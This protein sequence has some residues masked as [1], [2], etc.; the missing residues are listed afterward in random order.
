[1]SEDSKQ[2]T[3][4]N[5]DSFTNLL[6][7]RGAPPSASA[8]IY[9]HESRKSNELLSLGGPKGASVSVLPPPQSIS[10]ERIDFFSRSA[11]PPAASFA[12]GFKHSQIGSSKETVEKKPTIPDE[13]LELPN[14]PQLV[15]R[16]H[17]EVQRALYETPFKLV[18]F[19]S[20][21]LPTFDSID[22][23]DFIIED[24][25]WHGKHIHGA[26][27]SYFDLFL[28]SDRK[29]GN[30]ILEV[31]KTK[32]DS[33]PFV[34]FFKSL[35]ALFIPETVPQK[36]QPLLNFG[37]L[38]CSPIT[39]EEYLQGL[40]PIFRMAFAQNY[41][42]RVEAAKMLCDLFHQKQTQL[43]VPEV[44]AACVK[45]VEK[46]LDDGEF[47]DVRQ[48]AI[49]ALSSMIDVVDE[50]KTAA[51]QS[52]R[53]LSVVMK[54]VV[55]QPK[56]PTMNFDTIQIRRECG[57]VLGSLALYNVNE[58][59]SR[60]IKLVDLNGWK[61]ELEKVEDKKLILQR[62]RFLSELRKAEASFA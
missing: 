47:P 61:S 21:L 54:T 2:T 9:A 25:V 33:K 41:E 7:F 51:I 8:E 37:T 20:K 14:R 32:G 59:T 56:L 49:M 36:Q 12:S 18:T 48:F 15:V 43:Q 6:K 45:S 5:E 22:F 17:F 11:F 27:C 55:D 35:K 34:Q 23:S 44:V 62:D 10:G 46:L 24:S 31:N 28:Y 1:M 30:Y 4:S 13:S 53:I 42:A 39:D 57:K 29:S 60:I 40:Q 3:N 58:L 50:Y 26:T 38:S 16:T 19:V 52:D